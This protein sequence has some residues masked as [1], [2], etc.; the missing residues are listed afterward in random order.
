MSANLLQRVAGHITTTGGLL[1]GYDVMYYRWRD[2]ALN[3]TGKVALFRMTGTGGTSSN[4]QRQLQDVSLFL[5]SNADDA[6]QTDNDL[7]GVVQ[8][9]RS[10]YNAPS[11][12]NMAPLVPYTGPTFLLNGRALFELIIRAGTEDH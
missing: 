12:F 8:H 9:L 11:V 5:M 6:Q 3:G 4:R 2:D 10:E 1:S 7:L